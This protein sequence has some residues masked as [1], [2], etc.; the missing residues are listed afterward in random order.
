[1]LPLN[2]EAEDISGDDILP[3]LHKPGAEMLAESLI[4]ADFYI[5]DPEDV[6]TIVRLDLHSRAVHLRTIDG[7]SRKCSFTS[8]YVLLTPVLMSAISSLRTPADVEH[9][10][11]RQKVAAFGFRARIEEDDLPGLIAAIGA[12]LAYRLPWRED[13]FEGLRLARKYGSAREEARLAAAW[14]EGAQDPPPGD[15]VI[16]LVSSLRDS[17]KIMEALSHTDLVARRAN[18]LDGEET[19]ILLIQRGSLWLDRYELAHDPDYL[20]RARQC[21]KRSW[22][23][24]PSDACSDLYN[25]LRK[26]EN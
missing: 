21:A 19:R 12:A 10:R 24:A 5:D 11:M 6:A 1:V 25:R 9:D 8:G 14:L 20:D 23:I 4:G 7:L 22:A 3:L 15:L 16:A 13:R 18:G 2:I 26:L 17:G